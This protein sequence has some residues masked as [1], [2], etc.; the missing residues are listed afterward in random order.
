VT[1]QRHPH[2][3]GTLARAVLPRPSLWATALR[4]AVYLAPAGWWRRAPF[5]PVP[6]PDYLKFRMV[7]A[8]GG[9]GTAPPEAHDVVAYLQWCKAWPEAARAT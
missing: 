8:Y 1:E 7:T 2:H 9:D 5:L 4:Q 3:A 6:H